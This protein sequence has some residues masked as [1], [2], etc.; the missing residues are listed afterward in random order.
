M[1]LAPDTFAS[2]RDTLA[3]AICLIF[4]IAARV[5]PPVVQDTISS[6]ISSSVLAP[7]LALQRQTELLRASRARYGELAALRDSALLAGFARLEVD[8]ENAR[9]RGDV[10]RLED[11][12]HLFSLQPNASNLFPFIYV[13]NLQIH[14]HIHAPKALGQECIHIRRS[15]ILP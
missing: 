12:C 14:N 3:F 9:L 1:S 15:C 5:A 6:V 4:A 8:E 13:F 2:R 7:F 10:A 11:G